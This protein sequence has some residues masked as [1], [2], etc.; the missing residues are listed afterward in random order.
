[1]LSESES[2]SD[3]LRSESDWLSVDWWSSD[4]LQSRRVAFK[5]LRET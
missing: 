4:G 2:E 1:M 3:W 5:A